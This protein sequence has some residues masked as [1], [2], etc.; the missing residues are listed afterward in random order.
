MDSTRTS[1]LKEYCCRSRTLKGPS[2]GGCSSF[3]EVSTLTRICEHA[4]R[5][6]EVSPSDI[7]C[8][9]GGVCHSF[10]TNI[11]YLVA[12]IAAALREDVVASSLETQ[13]ESVLAPNFG[14]MGI[15]KFGAGGCISSGTEISRKQTLIGLSGLKTVFVVLVLFA[16]GVFLAIT[17]E[18]IFWTHRKFG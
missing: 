13:I 5:T 17:I 18:I 1:S 14:F 12:G 9:E 11:R 7:V 16:T 2:Y 15:L 4:S 3:R 8:R 10:E 6:L